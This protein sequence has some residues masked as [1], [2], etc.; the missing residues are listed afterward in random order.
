MSLHDI[1]VQ[2]VRDN[3]EWA[4]NQIEALLERALNAERRHKDECEWFRLASQKD[5][6]GYQTAGMLVP[7]GMLIRVGENKGSG[8]A[9]VFVPETRPGAAEEL[10]PECWNR[11]ADLE[12][13]D[14]EK[15]AADFDNGEGSDT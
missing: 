3:P 5:P 1:R 6:D 2:Q 7:G 10:C 14:A 11:R 9:L 8:L 12:A 13:T 15:L 4:A